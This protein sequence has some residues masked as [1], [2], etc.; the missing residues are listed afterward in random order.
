VGA[1]LRRIAKTFDR[2]TGGTGLRDRDD[3]GGS[4]RTDSEPGALRLEFAD[5]DQSL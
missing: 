2:I 4:M 3:A 1:T 5:F